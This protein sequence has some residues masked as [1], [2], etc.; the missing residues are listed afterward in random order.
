MKDTEIQDREVMLQ[1]DLRRRQSEHEADMQSLMAEKERVASAVSVQREREHRETVNAINNNNSCVSCSPN[2]NS[3]LLEPLIVRP[4]PPREHMNT[5]C[6]VS[7][8]SA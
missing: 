1:S 8:S 5:P 2:W 4:A 7:K 3:F 6:V